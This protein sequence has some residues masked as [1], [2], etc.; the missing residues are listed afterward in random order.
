M[1][2]LA[3]QLLD[4]RP[5][6]RVLEVG[7]GGGSLFRQ[8]LAARP[9]AAIGVDLSEQMVARACRRFRRPIAEGR[10]RILLGSAER[11]PV[12]DAEIDKACSLNS[13][14]FWPDPE[15]A[16]EEFARVLRPGGALLLGFEAPET[17]RAWPGHRYGFTVYDPAEVVRLAAG[18][19]LGNAEIHEGLEPKFGRIFCVKVERL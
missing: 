11:L 18:A 19:G 6:D 3:L 2:A 10:A 1:N 12:G 5:Q 15:G 13:V 17:L 8:I 9:V 16:M 14:Y 4:V 7:F